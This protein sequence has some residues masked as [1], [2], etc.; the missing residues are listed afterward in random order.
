MNP[1]RGGGSGA[2]WSHGG[3]SEGNEGGGTKLSKAP[4]SPARPDFRH[5]G[6]DCH[7][8]RGRN[9][10]T[11]SRGGKVRLGRRALTCRPLDAIGVDLNCQEEE[12]GAGVHGAALL[13][14]LNRAAQSIALRLKQEEKKGPGARVT[15]RARAPS[16]NPSPRA[17]T[18]ATFLWGGRVRGERRAH[19]RAGQR[20]LCKLTSG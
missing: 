15:H 11:C 16:T 4:D 3:G 10:P 14:H 8:H 18:H 20:Y 12:E 5:D 1:G 13:V 9:F 2:I 17:R 6:S 7:P 19:T